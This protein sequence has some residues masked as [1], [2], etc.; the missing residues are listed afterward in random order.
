MAIQ[1]VQQT[2]SRCSH[3]PNLWTDEPDWETFDEI[4]A[5]ASQ[6]RTGLLARVLP[7]WAWDYWFAPSTATPEALESDRIEIVARYR[8]VINVTEDALDGL[9]A[10]SPEELL[11]C[12]DRITERLAD[13]DQCRFPASARPLD[14]HDSFAA[15]FD[16]VATALARERVTAKTSGRLLA[17]PAAAFLRE[18][19]RE[20]I[21][22]AKTLLEYSVK[23]GRARRHDVA[24]E[25]RE[26]IETF[27]RQ[28]ER[29]A[30]D[31]DRP[32]TQA[33]QYLNLEAYLDSDDILDD[34]KSIDV[35]LSTLRETHR[36]ELLSHP[37]SEQIE[38][39]EAR[40]GS[41]QDNLVASRRKYAEL[42]LKKLQETVE[43]GIDDLHIR[44]ESAREDGELIQSP[45]EVVTRIA[46]L[47]D[48]IHDFRAAPWRPEL[49]PT[50]LSELP[51][52]ESQLDT[53]ER[54]V[55]EKVRFDTRYERHA[56]QFREVRADAA[57][58]LSYEQYLT[59]PTRQNLT[60]RLENL[61][62]TID[63]FAAETQF[64]R[65]SQAD[66]ERCTD[67]EEAITAIEAH[68]EGYNPRFVSQQQEAYAEFFS[69]IGSANL[70]LTVEQQQAVIRN[71]IY[72]QV[73]AA[74][75]TGKTLTLTTRVAYLVRV[76][77]IPPDRVL[78]VTYTK[79]ATQEMEERL[80]DQ[81]GI[82][83]VEVRT[84]NSFGNK[85]LQAASDDGV[86]TIDPEEKQH[87]IDEAIQSAREAEKSEF[88]KHYY[89]FLAHYETQ[90]LD[91]VDF[92]TKEDYVEARRDADYVTLGG[93][94]VKSR[95]EKAIAD[96]LYIHRVGY[97]YEARATWADTA[98]DKAGY[99]PD[100]YLPGYDIY[101]EHW[102]IDEAASVAPWFSQSSQE[103]RDKMGWA[104]RQFAD[105]E[106]ELIGTYQFEYNTN[107]LDR[108]LRHRLEHHGV[109]LD[110]IDFDELVE[111]VFED[112]RKENQIKD[113]FEKF[114]ENA[115]RFNVTVEE[116]ESNLASGNPRQYH[117]GQCG[118]RI[119]EQYADYL[120]RNQLID[121]IDQINEPRSLI[122]EDPERYQSQYDHLLVDEFQ[123]IGAGKRELIQALTGP[124]GPKLF[125]VGDD[126]QS[127]YSF[128]GAAVDNFTRFEDY[129][130]PPVRTDLTANFRSPPGI[131]ET[132]NHLI[133]HNSE[134]L[135]K[136]VQ[137][138]M[139][140]ETTPQIHTLRGYRGK[141]H[142]YMRRV[143]RYTIGLV[144][145]YLA[146]GADPSDIMIL[147]RYDAAVSYLDE[148]KRGLRSQEIPYTGS[149]DSD[150]YR[151][152]DGQQDGIPVYSIH[153][154]KGREADHVILVHVADG[155]LSFPADDRENELLDPVQPIE[156]GGIEEERRL[157]YVAVTRAERSLDLLTRADHES[158]FLEEIDDHVTRVDTGQVQPLE[159]VG[160]RMSVEVHVEEL[161]DPWSK[162]HQRGK[163]ADKYGGTAQF[164]SWASDLPP[165][166]ER[167]SWYWVEN[168][169][170]DEYKSEKE[171]V[172]TDTTTVEQL[173]EGSTDPETAAIDASD[174]SG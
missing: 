161:A 75:G 51:E 87:V 158:Q 99:T 79:N 27:N 83:G 123:D 4:E 3:P 12:P 109:D 127:I 90:Y 100:F 31:L 97:R 59:R 37:L 95:A 80:A 71:G 168:A 47:Q 62:D 63:E 26:T 49:P 55:E 140:V 128:Q 28:L 155:S 174:H 11:D 141:F 64:D 52:Y 48:M 112:N 104:R 138:T 145:E 78:V 67:L 14:D 70:D 77:D 39:I 136:T 73:I 65:L 38:R 151:G 43:T 24:R 135:E 74:A 171:L 165:T 117:F 2:A 152:P 60:A 113:E 122:E 172:I 81:F 61:T 173:P 133:E 23:Q 111:T 147:C 10:N 34:L 105:A 18:T 22:A 17:E 98:A 46:D 93:T 94:R 20:W 86:E 41:L 15:Y 150:Q 132:A 85:L 124:D 32:A 84:L 108:A 130:G 169:L 142:D 118:I 88:L 45:D 137:A 163:L 16:D 129:F 82:T 68:L 21:E 114:L 131:I 103:Y 6:G 89:Q 157:F 110:R 92:E 57:P 33:Q 101:I 146:A 9:A 106:F 134:Q 159:D 7:N 53:I 40:V 19:E 25:R 160:E 36:I 13:L 154:A 91:E 144:E 58:Y 50:A 121:F 1:V 69:D 115:K 166:L 139:D 76:Q 42:Q 170:V 167:G 54:F 35:A 162:Q 149:D 148:I 107:R 102:G 143:R 8:A 156:L 44:L 56:G 126:W 96:F 153:Q 125:A 66:R 29:L 5:Y 72:N 30:A 164:I 119:R 120:L 116:I